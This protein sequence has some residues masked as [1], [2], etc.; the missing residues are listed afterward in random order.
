MAIALLAGLWLAYV[1]MLALCLGMERHFKQVWQR[2]P[3]P[4]LRHGL[5]AGGWL[6]L[7][8]SLLASVAAWGWA[9]G[10]VGWFGLISLAGFG[11]VLLLPYRPRLAAGLP[12]F[13]MPL[14][15]LA[16]A[17]GL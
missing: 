16:W 7:V 17:V 6:A 3:R 8:L 13:A 1:G 11:L 2:S 5:R 14:M 10:P 9:M 15:L 4:A 12:L